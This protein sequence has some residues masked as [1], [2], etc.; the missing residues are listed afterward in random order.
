MESV[1]NA[2]QV[3]LPAFHLVQFIEDEEFGIQQPSG[4]FDNV[5]IFEVIV[6]QID[7]F[8]ETFRDF[9]C[10]IRFTHLTRAG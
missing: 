5:T 9:L 1:V 6:I 8:P 3:V 2:F 7:G 4:L 10:Q